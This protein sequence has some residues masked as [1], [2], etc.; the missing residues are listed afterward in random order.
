MLIEQSSA[1]P[2]ASHNLR[3]TDIRPCEQIDQA[4]DCPQLAKRYWGGHALTPTHLRV[5]QST[6]AAFDFECSSDAEEC[7]IKRD[8]ATSALIANA[9]LF[10]ENGACGMEITTDDTVVVNVSHGKW[11]LLGN[12]PLNTAC[13]SLPND[14]GG[15]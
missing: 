8:H 5:W 6:G 12:K 4:L 1:G 9:L 7:V 15:F 14:R 2:K 13:P 10:T 3:A 11:H